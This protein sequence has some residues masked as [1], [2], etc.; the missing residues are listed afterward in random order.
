MQYCMR[1]HYHEFTNFRQKKVYLLPKDNTFTL[2]LTAHIMRCVSGKI[3]KEYAESLLRL[4][5]V[6]SGKDEIG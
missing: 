3:E 6:A 5:K 4:V 1:I 2:L